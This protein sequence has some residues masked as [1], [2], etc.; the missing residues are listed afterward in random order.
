MGA[1]LGK[2]IGITLAIASVFCSIVIFINVSKLDFNKP[3][4]KTTITFKC[5]E[6]EEDKKD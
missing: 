4:F 3:I 1:I 2:I 5:S 6:K